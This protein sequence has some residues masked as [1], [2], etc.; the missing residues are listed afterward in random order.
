MDTPQNG[1]DV[2]HQSTAKSAKYIA[3][4]RMPSLRMTLFLLMLL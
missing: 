3:K 2:I 4:I 1:L